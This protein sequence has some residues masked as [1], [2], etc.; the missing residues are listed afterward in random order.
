VKVLVTGGT[1]FV[2][3][4][5]VRRL[6]AR[7]DEVVVF[8]RTAKAPEGRVSTVAWTPESPGPW[9]ETVRSV[10]AVIHLAGQSIMDQRWTPEFIETCKRSRVVPTTL[11]AKALAD[12]HASGGR[13]KTWVSASAVGYY[14][15]DTGDAQVD[16][17][18]KPAADNLAG[19]CEAWEAA[20]A[21]AESAG[22]R[23]AHA[24]IG[25]VL[26]K[27]GGAMAKLLPIYR[28]FVGGPVGSG[29]QYFPW[30]HIADTANALLFAIDEPKL[31]GAFNVTA[32][33]PVTADAFAKAM[34]Q[35][36]HR[37]AFFRVPAFALKIALGEQSRVLVGG[38][39]AVPK[40]LDDARF[41]FLYPE[42]DGAL[43]DIVS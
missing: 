26:G 29:R 41:A 4:E 14:G 25:I 11:L 16:E 43:Q 27:G 21:V 18:A 31:R 38:Q 35:A 1:G 40:K 22:I 37:P 33:A 20:T 12:A 15:L 28:A 17:T 10:D 7:G 39:R 8:S 34:G 13:C 3:K 30:I 23:V 2:G 6:V 5:V 19:M 9:T 32:P 36:L 24:R 42:I